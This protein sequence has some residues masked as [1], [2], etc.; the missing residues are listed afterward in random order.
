MARHPVQPLVYD[1]HGV[2]RFKKNAIVRFLLNTSKY[3]LDK[4]GDMDFSDS[5]WEQF[6]QL[7]GYSVSHFSEWACVT[8]ETL[9]QATNQKPEKVI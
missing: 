7:I 6:L 2:L 5:D 4:L 9:A 3:K 1:E 8:E